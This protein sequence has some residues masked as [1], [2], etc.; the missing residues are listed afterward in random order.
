MS[1]TNSPKP[2]LDYDDIF[3]RHGIHPKFREGIKAMACGV[4]PTPELKTRLETI[5]N[6]REC[7]DDILTRLSQPFSHLFTPKH[8]SLAIGDLV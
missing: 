1:L 5:T 8:E 7:L 6:Y 4:P 3:T 2:V